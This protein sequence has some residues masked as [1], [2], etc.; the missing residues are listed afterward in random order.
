MQ[1]RYF[2]AKYGALGR[3]W[4][5]S[6]ILSDFCGVTATLNLATTIRV[7]ATITKK[8]SFFISGT[9]EEVFSFRGLTK[10][11]ISVIMGLR[12]KVRG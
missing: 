11:E 7:R 9:T 1:N 10:K 2:G 12:R 3:M 6:F 5:F 4:D 8:K